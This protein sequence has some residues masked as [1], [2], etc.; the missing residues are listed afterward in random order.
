M[1]AAARAAYRAHQDQPPDDDEVNDDDT[2]VV[3]R[4]PHR[5][6]AAWAG[7][8]SGWASSV[9]RCSRNRVSGT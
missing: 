4:H 8:S 9:T 2:T 1:S 6:Y 7:A 5:A 3:L